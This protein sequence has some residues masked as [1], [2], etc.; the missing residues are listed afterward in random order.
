M[1]KVPFILTNKAYW[2]WYWLQTDFSGLKDRWPT[3]STNTLNTLGRDKLTFSYLWS[4]WS[5]VIEIAIW[6]CC[7]NCTSQAALVVPIPTSTARCDADSYTVRGGGWDGSGINP[8]SAAADCGWAGSGINPW[9][10]AA[11]CRVDNVGCRSGS[12]RVNGSIG[13]SGSALYSSGTMSSINPWSAA[14]IVIYDTSFT[15]CVGLPF[16]AFDV[17][18]PVGSPWSTWSVVIKP[19]SWTGRV[20]LTSQAWLVVTVMPTTAGSNAGFSCTIRCTLT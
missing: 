10:A 11:D 8:W 1:H 18:I 14:S 4:T 2:Y 5:V 16:T 13:S 3:N 7:M 9:G 6:T 17:V 19:T 15:A 12:C 20:N